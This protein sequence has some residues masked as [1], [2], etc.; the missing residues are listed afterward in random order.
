[1]T[2]PVEFPS[3]PLWIWALYHVAI[4]FFISIDL[5]LHRDAK[6][7]TFRNAI[8]WVILWIS[9]GVVT[10]VLVGLY[11]GGESMLHY[12]TAYL[13][14]Y[15]LSF[16][17][18]FVFAVIFAY[19]NVPLAYQTKTLYVGIVTAVV[20]RGL[21]IAAGLELIARF[22]WMIV[23]FGAV[24]IYSGYR[25]ARAGPGNVDP[26]R[27]FIVRS[28]KKVM[29]ISDSF[30]DSHFTTKRDGRRCFTPLLLALIAIETTD[31]VFALDSLP[32][33]IAITLNFF[34]AYTSNISAILGLR[35]LYVV[36]D[37]V[38]Y[39]LE[40]LNRGLSVVLVF[41]GAKMIAGQFGFVVPTLL[42]IAVVLAVIAASVVASVYIQRRRGK[43]GSLG[44][45]A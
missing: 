5:F 20:L 1:M 21:F 45:E 3:I 35:S 30:D 28:A 31:L 37:M 15:S 44:S 6:P 38:L 8:S 13:V 19:F 34:V 17:N 2:A 29:P 26:S 14:E 9:I 22:D 23:V 24:L 27:N 40:Y 42:S 16:D 12:F 32:A 4:V 10:G 41:F 7:P 36:L 11:L 18:L 33:V 43:Q 25:L 39:R